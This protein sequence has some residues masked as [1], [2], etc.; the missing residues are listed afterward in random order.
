VDEMV[1]FCL[2]SF[3]FSKEDREMVAFAC[4]LFLFFFPYS[5][6]WQRSGQFPLSILDKKRKEA[7]TEEG[8]AYFRAFP[9]PS[10]SGAGVKRKLLISSIFGQKVW[11]ASAANASSLS[12]P[13]GHGRRLTLPFTFLHRRQV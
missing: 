2:F 9:L 3:H 5:S 13:S 8:A 1:S 11:K 10:F 4:L 12:F 7:G 6:G